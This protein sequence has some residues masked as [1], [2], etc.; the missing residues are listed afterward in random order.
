VTTVSAFQLADDELKNIA[1]QL[2]RHCGAGGSVK[3]SVNIMQGDHRE[4]LINGLKVRGFK[5]KIA[6]G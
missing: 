3:D 2:K 5:A 4:T 1:T 6:G